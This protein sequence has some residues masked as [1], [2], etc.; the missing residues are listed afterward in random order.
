MDLYKHQ[1][2]NS[3]LKVAHHEVDEIMTMRNDGCIRMAQSHM[4][5]LYQKWENLTIFA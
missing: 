5:M 3:A 2:E 1:C 4:R